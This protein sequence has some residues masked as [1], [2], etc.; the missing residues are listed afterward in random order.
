MEENNQTDGSSHSNLKTLNVDSCF[1]RVYDW[2]E[3]LQD[4]TSSFLNQYNY[5]KDLSK[6][7][8]DAGSLDSILCIPGSRL[9]PTGFSKIDTMG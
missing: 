7:D 6:D 3:D 4:N 2:D 5:N 8:E 1:S 9:V